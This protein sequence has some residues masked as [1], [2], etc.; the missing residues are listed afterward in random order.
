MATFTGT[1]GADRMRG[2]TG[3]DTFRSSAGNDNISAGTGFETYV[4]SLGRGTARSL[5]RRPG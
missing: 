4:L 1:S 5:G 2:T 3:D